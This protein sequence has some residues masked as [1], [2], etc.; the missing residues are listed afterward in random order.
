MFFFWKIGNIG[1]PGLPGKGISGS[2]GLKGKIW[3][4]ICNWF[5]S[6]FVNSIIILG[7]LLS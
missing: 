7:K 3:S 4:V 5:L 1:L 2:T 6:L